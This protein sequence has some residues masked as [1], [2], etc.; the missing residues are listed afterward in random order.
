MRPLVTARVA[1]IEVPPTSPLLVSPVGSTAVPM[2]SS[3]PEPKLSRMPLRCPQHPA[4]SIFRQSRLPL[5]NPSSYIQPY[6][7]VDRVRRAAGPLAVE[8][9][10]GGPGSGGS[11]AV[12]APVCASPVERGGQ[13]DERRQAA[14]DPLEVDHHEQLVGQAE[15]P[16]SSSGAPSAGLPRALWRG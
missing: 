15:L 12:S 3:L 14:V 6:D 10:I 7:G 4:A 1:A 9:E 5:L 8:E 11:F 2:T 16:R 13:P